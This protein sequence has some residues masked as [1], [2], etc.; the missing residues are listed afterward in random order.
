MITRKSVSY[1]SLKELLPTTPPAI[2]SL[3]HSSSWDDILIKNKLVK[4]AAFAY[5]Q[6][7]ST[8]SSL[9]E[10]C[11]KGLLGRL[12]ERCCFECGCISWIYDVVWM[13]VKE[14]FGETTE[15]VDDDGDDDDD[16]ETEMAA[17]LVSISVAGEDAV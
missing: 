16:E 10:V 5:L 1:T 9:P 11:K 6:P 15:E 14:A 7:M 13:N 8:M 12:K 17:L 2:T 4:H 3:S